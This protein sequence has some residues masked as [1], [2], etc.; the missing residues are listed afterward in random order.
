MLLIVS[1]FS[2]RGA[3]GETTA[4]TFSDANTQDGITSQENASSGTTN[5]IK[6]KL[7]LDK[8]LKTNGLRIA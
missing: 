3:Q 7:I 4:S 6:F 5:S 2:N 8:K 1:S